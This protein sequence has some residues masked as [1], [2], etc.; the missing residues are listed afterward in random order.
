MYR[1]VNESHRADQKKK[2][3]T[4]NQQL[5]HFKRLKKIVIE[6]RDR[7]VKYRTKQTENKAIV[8]KI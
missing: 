2:T 5:L 7:A 8:I 4:L 1:K 6:L 3:Q